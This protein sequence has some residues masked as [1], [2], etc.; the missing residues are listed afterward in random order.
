MP[1]PLLVICGPTATGKSGLAMALAERT[2][3]EIVSADSVQVYR[4]LDIGSAKPTVGDRKLVPHHLV[5]VCDPDE[6]FSVADYQRLAG[7]A[8]AAVADRGRLPLLVGG[9]GLYIQAV[10]DEY[11]FSPEAPPSPAVRASL[12]GL[13]R[14]EGHQAV[15]RRLV[16]VDPETAGRL[17]PHDLRRVIR[18]LEVWHQTGRPPSTAGALNESGRYDP[19][20]V[21][22]AMP[23]ER[24]YAR[25]EARVD[26]MM[27]RGFLAE[28][29]DLRARG[30]HDNLRSLQS[31]GYRELMDYLRG[32]HTLPEAVRLIKRNTRRLAKR[33]LTWFRRDDRIHWLVRG[34]DAPVADLVEDI[35][36][37]LRGK[38]KTL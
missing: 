34:E 15:Y 35:T 26:D 13:A 22:L 4:Y 38:W 23:R 31:V 36:R 16:E 33:Q 3:C 27:R 9:S 18:S 24:L 10:V 19:L 7:E 5:D 17:H 20:F 6:P 21:G 12:R 30:Y 14:A 1:V 2:A 29:T 37:L 8:I 25:I 28:V 11:R 32:R